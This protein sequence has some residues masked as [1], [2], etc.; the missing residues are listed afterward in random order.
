[1]Q[2]NELNQPE[3]APG[4]VPPFRAASSLSLGTRERNTQSWT[5]EADAQCELVP[6]VSWF[7][8]EHLFAGYRCGSGA[9]LPTFSL[10]TNQPGE[11]GV[12]TGPAGDARRT[13]RQAHRTQW[14]SQLHGEL[15][16][17]RAPRCRLKAR[18]STQAAVNE[19]FSLCGAGLRK[20][21]P[22]R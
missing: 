18:T 10:S 3:G 13:H 7:S 12:E 15:E 22:R 9:V 1:M 19:G 17:P 20:K 2:P 16:P 11:E 14:V 8:D 21:Q 4:S 5:P 6:L